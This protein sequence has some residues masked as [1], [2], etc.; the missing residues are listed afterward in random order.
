VEVPVEVPRRVVTLLP[1]LTPQVVDL[2][3]DST[4]VVAD[5]TAEA[6]G[7][8]ALTAAVGVAPMVA[9]VITNPNTH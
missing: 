3:A 1:H 6:V 8:V 5:P 7:A 4:V 9:V 2:A